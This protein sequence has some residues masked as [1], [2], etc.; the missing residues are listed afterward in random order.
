MII[1]N[2]QVA[3]I[4]TAVLLSAAIS[5]WLWVIK[6]RF[7]KSLSLLLTLCLGSILTL[8]IGDNRANI[9]N[10]TNA[11]YTHRDIV[12]Q[13]GHAPLLIDSKKFKLK[14][15]LL[16]D[17]A[18]NE[19]FN[20]I[21]RECQTD[22]MHNSHNIAQSVLLIGLLLLMIAIGVSVIRSAKDDRE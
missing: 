3:Y 11:Y 1:T 21:D 14:E 16:F 12:C 18:T 2:D 7:H 8:Y 5:Y 6:A 19:G 20:I 13:V 10:I 4:F 17:K 22:E 9:E 15:E